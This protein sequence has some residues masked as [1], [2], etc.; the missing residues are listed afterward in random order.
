MIA[1]YAVVAG[2]DG[3]NSI[4]IW[5]YTA[6]F[7]VLI[8]ASLLLI[9]NGFEVL[10]SQLVV[11]IAAIIPLGFS[12][13]LVVENLPS[14]ASGYLGFTIVG[15]LAI[16]VTRYR[17]NPQL[18]TIVLATV[19]GSAG[20]VIFLLPILLFISSDAPAGLLIISLGGATIGIG[21]LMLTFWKSGKP[22]L[23]VEQIL[24][25]LPWLLLAMTISF[26]LGL[27]FSR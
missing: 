21:G 17:A 26:T 13:G 22:L 4:A 23:S 15:F 19:H 11:I 25:M 8:V 16:L 12:L 1:A 2:I 5:A 6:A 20:L 14:L 24:R 27:G 7:G 3:L 10:E 9:I 18:A